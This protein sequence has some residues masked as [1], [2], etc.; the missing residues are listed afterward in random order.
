MNEN[1]NSNESKYKSIDDRNQI[2]KNQNIDQQRYDSMKIKITKTSK[3][4]SVSLNATQK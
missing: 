4:K 1:T 2:P 3:Q